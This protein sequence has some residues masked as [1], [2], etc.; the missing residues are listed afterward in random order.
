MKSAGDGL[1][2]GLRRGAQATKKLRDAIQQIPEEVMVYLAES[3][4]FSQIRSPTLTLAEIMYEEGR[5]SLFAEVLHYY[6]NADTGA[7]ER[8][9]DKAIAEARITSVEG[10]YQ[11]ME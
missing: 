1:P 8:L 3:S 2:P 6:T 11:L 4:G 10:Q 5:R 7:I 9:R